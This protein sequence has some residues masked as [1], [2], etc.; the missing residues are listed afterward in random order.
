[1]KGDRK[2]IKPP[3]WADRLLEWYCRPELLEDLQGDLYEF[4]YRRVET[5]GIWNAR[6]HYLLDALKFFRLYTVK[7]LKI[8]QSMTFF[9]LLGNY[10]KTSVRSIA[11]N[12]LFSGINIIG[13][14]VAMSVGL[15]MITYIGESLTFDEF[16]EKKDR[17]YRVITTYKGVTNDDSFKLASTSLYLGEKLREEYSGFEKV[18]I[19]RRNFWA[20]ISKGEHT[21]N[22][23][24]HFASPE[25][26]DVFS[27]ELIAGN[28]ATALVEPNSIVLTETT[29]RKLFKEE[30]PVGQI[31][32]ADDITY[33]IT[34]LMRDIPAN[35]H[36]QFEALASLETFKLNHPKTEIPEE[37]G[38]SSVWMNHI[39]LLLE[40]G[41]NPEDINDDLA[42]I[43]SEENI[44]SD[45]VTIEHELGSLSAIVPG[46]DLSNQIGPSISW[47]AV[48]QLL[49]L[50]LII[51]LSACFNY[52]NLSIA[53]SL[54]RAKEV[55]IRK[56]VGATRSQ[57]FTQFIIEA[58]IISLLALLI[59]VGLYLLIKPE[60]V[61][62]IADGDNVGMEFRWMHIVNFLVFAI[63]IGLV[64]GVLP[65]A[66][67]SKLRAISILSDITKIKLLK[68]VSLRR[69][70]IVL[71]FAISMIMIISATI[72]YQQY[73]FSINYDL[74][75]NSDNILN[76]SL[77]GNDAEILMNELAKHPEI[78]AMSRS[79]MVPSTGSIYGERV[80]YKDPLDSVLIHIN[81]VDQAY[82][83]VHD[84]TFLAGGTFPYDR[85]PDDL[86]AS[87]IIIDRALSERFGFDT[88]QEALGETLKLSDERLGAVQVVGVI[89]NYQYTNL[90]GS[91]HPS[92]LIPGGEDGFQYINLKVNTTDIIALLDKIEAVWSSVDEVHPFE[93]YFMNDMIQESYDFLEVIY[94]IF[95]F[96]A[97]LAI[98]ISTMGLLGIAVFTTET[99]IKEI[100]IRK[101]MGATER[102]LIVLLSRSFL[103]ML[104]ISAVIA[105]PFTY[106]FFTSLVL[107]DFKDRIAIGILELTPG[108]LVIILIGLLTIGWQTFRA[109]RTNPA[110]TLRDE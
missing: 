90:E 49:G 48:Y 66:V 78:V 22:V 13:L 55:G 34:G 77:I 71:Q 44:N 101:V 27:F 46:P 31:V 4:F 84:F 62:S 40:E 76:I 59:S 57:V 72:A 56:V 2:N 28:E 10:Y 63:C 97:V 60:F 102:N 32:Q 30:N 79:L 64:A 29:A 91:N 3:K 61:H 37:Y 95:T 106:Y 107:A 53:R 50:T 42:M 89:E 87:F 26:F 83:S 33:T 73:K 47:T 35:S 80:K 93:A 96:L 16:H 17:I 68:G 81:Y 52:T 104:I 1:M 15:L 43:A 105:I 5:K 54:R 39:Y 12:K 58:V 109:A 103:L 14:A 36:I 94:R 92:A 24:G 67:L 20:D 25:F 19:M 21:I 23:R 41:V 100:S 9:N 7:P 82:T 18:L 88:P 110:D 6:W 74:G 8:I 99:K 108:V 51:I 65:S 70:L 86:G 45:R 11:R 69:I 98:S 75:F 85:K 38:W